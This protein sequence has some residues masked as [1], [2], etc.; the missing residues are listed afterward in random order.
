[1]NLVIIFHTQEDWHH[2]AD[3]LYIYIYLSPLAVLPPVLQ[4]VSED[5]PKCHHVK[6]GGL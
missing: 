2:L 6:A 3:V 1:M 5:K 4:G